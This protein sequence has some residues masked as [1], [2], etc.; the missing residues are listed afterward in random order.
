MYDARKCI[1]GP[2]NPHTD[3]VAGGCGMKA[4]TTIRDG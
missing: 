2:W 4:G 3:S 1:G